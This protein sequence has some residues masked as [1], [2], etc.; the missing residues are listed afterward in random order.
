MFAGVSLLS[1][2]SEKLLSPYCTM[3]IGGERLANALNSLNSLEFFSYLSRLEENGDTV[4]LLRELCVITE[5]CDLNC[6]SSPRG[7]MK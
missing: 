1:Y 2:N 6:S 7:G 5:R 4:R 3:N